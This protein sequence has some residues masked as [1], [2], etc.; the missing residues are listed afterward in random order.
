M[1]G[2]RAAIV[3]VLAVPRAEPYTPETTMPLQDLSA[4]MSNRV[5]TKEASV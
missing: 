4:R 2:F 5:G 3:P 1:I